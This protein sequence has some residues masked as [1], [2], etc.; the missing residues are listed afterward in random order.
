MILH[1]GGRDIQGKRIEASA[2]SQD[3]LKDYAGEYYSDELLVTYTLSGDQG[4]LYLQIGKKD[5]I[6][7]SVMEKNAFAGSMFTGTFERN[8]D[9]QVIGFSL[10]AGRVKNMKFARKTH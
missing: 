7:L 2:L 3:Q 6:E 8:A 4:K 9:G 1:Q 10:D 5:K